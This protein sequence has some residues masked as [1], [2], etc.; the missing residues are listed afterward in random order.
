MKILCNF[1]KN[2]NSV[3]S[4]N[5]AELQNELKRAEGLENFLEII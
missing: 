1:E 2:V 4:K 5:T 3:M